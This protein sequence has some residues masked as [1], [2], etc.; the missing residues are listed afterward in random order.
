MVDLLIPL[1]LGALIAFRL[2]E[3]LVIDDGPFDLFF[4]ARGWANRAPRN[5]GLRRN[6]SNVLECV[7]CVGLWISL[8]LGVVFYMTNSF[9]LLE[10]T[11]LAFSIAGL[12]S[13]LA[14]KAGRS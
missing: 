4:S 8:A 11:L 3:L 14:N 7:H 6:L 2:A 12:Q 13:I 9:T 1:L 5:N 10:S